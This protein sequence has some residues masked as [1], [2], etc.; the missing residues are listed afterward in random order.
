MDLRKRGDM[1]KLGGVEGG[2]IVVKM[3]CMREELKIKKNN[4]HQNINRT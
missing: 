1:G 2:G 3:Y 4:S